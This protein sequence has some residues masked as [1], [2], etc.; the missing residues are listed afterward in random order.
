MFLE[1]EP[2]AESYQEQN[3]A[4]EPNPD[5]SIDKRISEAKRLRAE[6]EQA[7]AKKP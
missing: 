4:L 6:A 5:P 7:K 1:I 2:E 3:R